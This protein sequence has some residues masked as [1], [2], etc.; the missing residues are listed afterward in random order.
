MEDFA[1]SA[2]DAIFCTIELLMPLC[3]Q[4]FTIPRRGRGQPK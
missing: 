2:L 3:F 1:V 4:Y